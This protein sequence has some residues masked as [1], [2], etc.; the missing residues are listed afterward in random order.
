MTSEMMEQT[1]KMTEFFMKPYITIPFSILMFALIGLIWS[2]LVGA[3]VKK[4]N[5]GAF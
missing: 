3:I 4:D 2:L 1:I 5:P